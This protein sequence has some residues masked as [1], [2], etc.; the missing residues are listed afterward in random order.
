MK[1]ARFCAIMHLSSQLDDGSS[2]LLL[3]SFC[4][5]LLL[6]AEVP[7]EFSFPVFQY[8]F[9]MIQSQEELTSQD[10]EIVSHLLQVSPCS[11]ENLYFVL[12]LLMENLYLQDSKK[13]LSVLFT[14][15]K[16]NPKVSIKDFYGL[17]AEI[18]KGKDLIGFVITLLLYGGK[19]A[20]ETNNEFITEALSVSIDEM[21]KD[22]VGIPD[23]D[24]AFLARKGI[25]VLWLQP[26]VLCPF[27]FALLLQSSD[28][29]V[30]VMIQ[31]YLLR[32][33]VI[34]Y[35]IAFR[36]YREAV[37]SENHL[38]DMHSAYLEAMNEYSDGLEASLDE[39]PRLK[40]IQP[41]LQQRY[42]MRVYDVEQQVAMF[43]QGKERSVI[44]HLATEISILF[45]NSTLY[46]HGL[47]PEP[48]K[49]SEVNDMFMHEFS[50]E[51]PRTMLWDYP[52][53]EIE[54][55]IFALE[56]RV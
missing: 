20:I 18:G 43:K 55:S 6:E 38:P 30:Q 48:E 36:A 44:R 4:S 2:D 27:L 52:T 10:W 14:L 13:A 29:H 21:S 22:L 12:D 33:V 54:L 19:S 11:D 51:L 24:L 9:K 25:A 53:V 31:G 32:W 35:P 45:A 15:V 49:S 3:S 8:Y 16:R 56:E 28:N 39:G 1:A 47:N 41:S 37:T 50:M 26:D 42:H 17:V 40:E 46:L 5:D 23:H 7:M 34:P